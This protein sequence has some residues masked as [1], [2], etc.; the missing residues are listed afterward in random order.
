MSAALSPNFALQSW[1]IFNSPLLPIA[2]AP[3]SQG[4][5]FGRRLLVHAE[6][7]G[8]TLGHSVIRLY[9]NKLFMKNIGLYLRFGYRIDREEV[10]GA[11]IAVHMSKPIQPDPQSGR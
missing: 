7:V 4:K 11:R 1:P 9:T 10:L 5:G 6:A 2:V 8:S 3:A